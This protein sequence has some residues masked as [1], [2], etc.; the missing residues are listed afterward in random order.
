MKYPFSDLYWQK[1]KYFKESPCSYMS[2]F[3]DSDKNG[4]SYNPSTGKVRD[5][6]CSGTEIIRYAVHR[7]FGK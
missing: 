5:K 7:N 3:E 6:N 1:K 4:R 2:G